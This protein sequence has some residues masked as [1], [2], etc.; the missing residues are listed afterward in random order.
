MKSKLTR[1]ESFQLNNFADLYAE[2]RVLKAMLAP[3]QKELRDQGKQ[4]KAILDAKGNQLP[5]TSDKQK[6]LIEMSTTRSA[7]TWSQSFIEGYFVNDSFRD[8]VK[9]SSLL[10]NQKGE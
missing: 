8:T 3:L 4:V 2:I 7:I 5:T 10:D 9:A 1:K 6:K